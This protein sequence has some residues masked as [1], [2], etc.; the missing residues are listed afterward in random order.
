MDHENT[1][2]QTA[3]LLCLS[4]IAVIGGVA[5]A[6]FLYSR[7]IAQPMS[8]ALHPAPAPAPTVQRPVAQAKGDATTV[9]PVQAG[10]S[11]HATL[12]IVPD[13]PKTG[14]S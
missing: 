10:P 7:S 2:Q 4:T 5:L 9:A 1:P 11:P 14:D 6:A 13:L 3:I 12:S 8:S